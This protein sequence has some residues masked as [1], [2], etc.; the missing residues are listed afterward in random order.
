[1]NNLFQDKLRVINVGLASFAETI[2]SSDGET[3]QVDWAPP[4]TGRV[5]EAQV[6][7]RLAALP[8]IAAANKRAFAA[9][10]EAR[11]VLA[12]I[13][14]ARDSI[15]GMRERTIL[16]AG[17][18]IPW[19][20]MCGPMQGAV[21][22]AILYEGWAADPEA[23]RT[24]AS[25]GGISFAPCHDHAAV[26]PMAGIISPN[27]PVWIVRNANGGNVAFSNLNEG[28]GKVLRFGANSREVIDRLKW[29]TAVLAPTLAQAFDVLGEIE[30]KPLIAQALHMGDEVHNRNAAASSLLLKRLVPAMLRSGAATTDV[31]A[32]VEFI[33]GND[34][35][36]LNISM[37]CAK[38]CWMPRM[39]SAAAAWSQRCAATA[40]SS[41][42]A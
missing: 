33:A 5:L 7:A 35:F 15:S 20:G 42:S 21:I 16:H 40:S 6:L 24:L 3:V 28:L 41:A 25:E 26:G 34:H 10:T 13:G 11:P 14:L 37:A 4:G 17:P 2:A 30:L 8:E 19:S 18:P 39:G 31:A 1:M 38:P 12:G 22:G 32:A 27:M 23:A 9:Y 36:F 29:M